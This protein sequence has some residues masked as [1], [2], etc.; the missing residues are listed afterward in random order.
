MNLQFTSFGMTIYVIYAVVI[1]LAIVLPLNLWILKRR[2]W[3]WWAIGA[4]AIPLL[5]APIIEEI[6]IAHNFEKLCRDAGV[7]VYKKVEADGYLNDTSRSVGSGLSSGLMYKDPKSLAEF[8]RTGFRYKEYMLRD[9]RAWHVERR[10]GG[11]YGQVLDKPQAQYHYKFAHPKQEVPVGWKLEKREALV[12]DVNENEVIAR[13]L[14]F[15]RH[16]SIIESLWIS[17][18]GSGM[19]ICNRPLNDHDRKTLTGFPIYHTLIPVSK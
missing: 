6:W 15:N 17:L 16:P 1:L 2:S 11:V 19:V 12:V 10:E 7:H 4:I 9:G 13:E 5:A 3:K 14:S 8:D 18:I